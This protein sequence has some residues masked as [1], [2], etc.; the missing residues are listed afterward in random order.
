MDDNVD[1]G[2]IQDVIDRI[3]QDS[4]GQ[5]NP[6]RFAEIADDSLGQPNGFARVTSGS[7][8]MIDQQTS[9]AGTDGS[10]PDDGNVGPVR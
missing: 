5:I 9:H 6:A 8:A 3:G 4:F 2:V 1:F 10:H 7:I